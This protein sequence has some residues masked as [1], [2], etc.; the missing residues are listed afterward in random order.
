MH[1]VAR[2]YLGRNAARMKESYDAKRDLTHYKPGDLVWYANSGSQL[3]L[4][5]KLRVPFQGPYLILA[6]IGDL[7]YKI[8]LD[9][10]GKQKVVQHNK[11]KP[12]EGVHNLLWAKSALKAH[13][14]QTK[15]FSGTRRTQEGDCDL[16]SQPSTQ[17][18]SVR[19]SSDVEWFTSPQISGTQVKVRD[20]GLVRQSRVTSQSVRLDDC[21]VR[22]ICSSPPM[23]GAQVSGCDPL[24]QSSMTSWSSMLK[25]IKLDLKVPSSIHGRMANKFYRCNQCDYK[26]KQYSNMCAH[27]MEAHFDVK[28][29]PFQCPI[30]GACKATKNAFRSHR[31]QYHKGL[32]YKP[33]GS[34][35]AMTEL[36]FILKH[37]LLIELLPGTSSDC[38]LAAEPSVGCASRTSGCSLPCARIKG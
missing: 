6:K 4:A 29:V 5:P 35:V 20:C 31:R 3:D 2:K 22:Q 14:K 12:Y 27:M 38:Q 21:I 9:A 8:Q 18:Q 33:L 34:G 30:C 19:F 37:F 28:D 17:T 7:D 16:A 26:S 1:D 32:D 11:L 36:D 15:N 13:A 10:K 25:C 23:G 24:S